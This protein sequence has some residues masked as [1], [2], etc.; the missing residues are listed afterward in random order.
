MA[1]SVPFATVLG[2]NPVSHRSCAVGEKVGHA[3]DTRIRGRN[4]HRLLFRRSKHRK[5]VRQLSQQRNKRKFKLGWISGLLQLATT[6]SGAPPELQDGPGG[7][8]GDKRETTKNST[9]PTKNSTPCR[10]T[11]FCRED[12]A[13]IRQRQK[14]RPSRYQEEEHQFKPTIK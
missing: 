9:P 10:T 2:C 8:G 4:I 11:N 5:Q 7:E 13:E 3:S 12:S 1:G 14:T 6:N